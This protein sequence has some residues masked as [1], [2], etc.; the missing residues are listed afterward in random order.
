MALTVL[1]IPYPHWA[2]TANTAEYEDN[3]RTIERW[4]NL[5]RCP[6]ATPD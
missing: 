3:W 1:Q 4:A 6:A 2:A 5:A